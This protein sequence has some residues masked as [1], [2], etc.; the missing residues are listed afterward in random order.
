M[1]ESEQTTNIHPLRFEVLWGLKPLV[2]DQNK[3]RL[4]LMEETKIKNWMAAGNMKKLALQLRGPNSVT[5]E[6][7]VGLP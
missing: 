2:R 5:E 1:K 3:S 7:V 4:P 6:G